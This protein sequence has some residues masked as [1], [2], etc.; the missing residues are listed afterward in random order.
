M[1][2]PFRGRCFSCG[3]DDG[4]RG[5]FQSS[6]LEDENLKLRAHLKL[7]QIRLK[8]ALDHIE[9]WQKAY[10]DNNTNWLPPA[11]G[12]ELME[13]IEAILKEHSL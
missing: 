4:F 10:G 2:L 11:G 9:D 1:L 3:R 6:V 7:A 8:A 13:N 12:V 5:N